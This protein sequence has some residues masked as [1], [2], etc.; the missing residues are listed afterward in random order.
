MLWFRR[1][2]SSD[3]FC[4]MLFV[5]NT[6]PHTHTHSYLFS[7][8]YL[9]F[10]VSVFCSIRIRPFNVCAAAS[11]REWTQ[12]SCGERE[13][14]K[15][16]VITWFYPS[17]DGDWIGCQKCMTCLEQ[18]TLSSSL[19]SLS[20]VAAAT[21]AIHPLTVCTFKTQIINTVF[22]VPFSIFTKLSYILYSKKTC[23]QLY[24]HF[25]YQLV[26]HQWL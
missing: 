16:C 26:R 17:G 1:F 12:E 15:L 10:I 24:A 8:F 2:D 4:L 14:K 7:P 5:S 3:F 13:E 22:V 21:T 25:S 18:N 9:S 20:L 6:L 19:C 23:I 11:A